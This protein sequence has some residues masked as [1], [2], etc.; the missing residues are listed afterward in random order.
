MLTALILIVLGLIGAMVYARHNHRQMVEA[1]PLRVEPVR[2]Q[3]DWS[4]LDDLDGI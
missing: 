2:S 3:V 1:V 4:V